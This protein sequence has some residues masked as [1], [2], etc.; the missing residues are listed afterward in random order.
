MTDIFVDAAN[1]KGDFADVFEADD[2]VSYFYL[3]QLANGS[4]G[5]VLGAVQVYRA[6]PDFAATDVAVRWL[7]DETK[8]AVFIKHELGAYF[9]LQSGR[10]YPGT[11]SRTQPGA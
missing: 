3:Y 8:V 6:V 7:D 1:K 9:D 2:S 10:E 4:G 11:F 5:K